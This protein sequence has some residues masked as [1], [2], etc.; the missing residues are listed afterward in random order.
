[1]VLRAIERGNGEIAREF[2]ILSKREGLERQ[3]KILSDF[4]KERRNREA[5]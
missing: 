1:M 2:V 5:E 3:S 4:T